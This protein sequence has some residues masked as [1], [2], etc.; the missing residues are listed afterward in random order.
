MSLVCL[1]PLSLDDLPPLRHSW[2][3]GR[4]PSRALSPSVPRPALDIAR[5]RLNEHHDIEKLSWRKIAALRPYRG[6]PAGTLCSIAKG[7]EPKKPIYRS[8][9]GL[10]AVIVMSEEMICA[11]EDC[12]RKFIPNHP[13]RRYCPI[14]HPP[15]YGFSNLRMSHV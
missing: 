13:S 10:P 14:C 7:R 9:L 4:Q 12:E 2:P 5:E 3:R 1:A 11:A 8:K 15:R 6:I